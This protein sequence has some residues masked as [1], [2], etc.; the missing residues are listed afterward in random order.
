M[1]PKKQPKY[2][3]VFTWGLVYLRANGNY[4]QLLQI[5]SGRYVSRQI[6]VTKYYC[7]D[8]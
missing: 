1:Y 6:V 7:E 2:L 8:A 5:K 4:L 3:P